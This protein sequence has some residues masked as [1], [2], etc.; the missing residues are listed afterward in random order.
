MR[1]RQT[2]LLYLTVALFLVFILTPV[3]V[4]AD[5]TPRSIA[6]VSTDLYEVH[7]FKNETVKIFF[8]N[9]VEILALDRP[10]I[11]YS[12]S[13][14]NVPLKF[15]D[16]SW[17]KEPIS[18]SLGEGIGF[19]IQGKSVSW[20]LEVYPGKP[21]LI[22]RLQYKNGTKKEQ[23]VRSLISLQGILNQYSG[24][25][26][27]E[28]YVVCLG[29]GNIFES[30]I[31]YPQWT[32]NLDLKTQWDLMIYD[33]GRKQSLLAGFLTFDK[34]FS[35][36][37]LSKNEKKKVVHLTA[38]SIFDPPIKLSPGESLDAEVLY[39]SLG[40]QSPHI[41]LE[42]YGRAIFVLNKLQKQSSFLPH[43]WDSWSTALGKDI[44]EKIILENIQF[45]DKHLKR[46]GW[47]HLAIDA[48]WERGPAD[49]EPNP[50]KF[51]HGLKPIVEE[52]HN[53]GMT[54]GL[55]IDLF[56][57]PENS[58]LFKEHPDWLVSPGT[59]G[60]LLLGN[61][62]KILDITIP[63]AYVYARDICKKISQDW[64]FDGLVEADFVY[65]LLLGEGYKD[66]R[67]T[68]V[69]VLRKGLESIREGLGTD[70]FLMT[71]IPIPISG[72]YADGIRIG[73]DNK[74][75]WSSSAIT[76]NWGCMESLAN[77]AR[78]YY[79]FP[80][81]GA[82]DQDCVFL[83]HDETDQRWKV[84]EEN[85][86]TQSQV[87]AW[88]TGAALTGGVFKIG[89]EFTKLTPD[90]INL[91]Q[92]VIP[93]TTQPACPIDLFENPHPQKWSLP[94]SGPVL[95]GNILAVFNW[96]TKSSEKVSVFLEQLGLNSGK[97]YALYDF[98]NESFV[99]IIQNAFV[100]DLPPTSVS[101]FGIHPLEKRLP[102]FVASN[103][104][105]SQG[106]MD[107]LEYNYSPDDKKITG[108]MKVVD[109]TNYKLTFYDPEKRKIKSCELSIPDVSYQEKDGVFVLQ[110]T[111]PK[112]TKEISWNIG[113]E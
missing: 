49:W 78:R 99:G 25:G 106:I 58:K 53:R 36:V 32:N 71:M 60:K 97:L 100:V 63:E 66:G 35:Q 62:R 95:N 27:D 12:D 55:W 37:I 28:K 2:N 103:H 50:E 84:S 1:L 48:G 4:K 107:V 94:L 92:K 61:D 85:K 69:Q 38:E 17:Y 87:V 68:K 26:I 74:P 22:V 110:F 13:D 52:L 70:K 65:H 80:N 39:L 73:F 89:E 90:E 30:M 40:E 10:A 21:F 88:I 47:N 31:D 20:V 86:L 93:K 51:P 41:C 29:N 6:S 101:L 7:L 54:A 44:N 56:T 11:V 77:F 43:G 3:M 83:G 64:G 45:V 14:E 24:K 112:D 91:L 8:S 98:W 19:Y 81:L 57:V 33:K 96:D 15:S 75:L 82:P 76:G 105:I 46:F 18:S 111:V 104:H 16:M 67:L 42:R 59:K 34:G 113:L 102:I 9:G 5:K 108:K 72:M 79:L 109:E 23:S